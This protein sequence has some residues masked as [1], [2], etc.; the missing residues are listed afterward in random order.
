MHTDEGWTQNT[1]EEQQV[2]EEELITRERAETKQKNKDHKTKNR[3]IFTLT[4]L[5]IMK[6]QCKEENSL[7]CG[8]WFLR[9]WN[10]KCALKKHLDSDVSS[11][12]HF[13]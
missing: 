12:S 4:V 7:F 1:C 8:V 9:E 11:F 5:K 6:L 13:N 3:Q 2:A 10:K